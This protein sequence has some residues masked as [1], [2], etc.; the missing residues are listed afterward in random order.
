MF[1]LKNVVLFLAGVCLVVWGFRVNMDRTDSDLATKE[2]N[3]ASEG[4]QEQK[5]ATP[6]PLSLSSAPARTRSQ[7]K[8]AVPKKRRS[9][10]A[11]EKKT[12]EKATGSQ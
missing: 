10:T 12:P 11:L 1:I 3:T 7:K 4:E 6:S 5:E 2:E 8:A 9:G